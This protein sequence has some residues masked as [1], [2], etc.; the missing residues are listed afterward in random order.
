MLCPLE[1]TVSKSCSTYVLVSQMKGL[2]LPLLWSK[3]QNNVKPTS[4]LRFGP[5]IIQ[6]E[7]MSSNTSTYYR[8][9]YTNYNISIIHQISQNGICTPTGSTHLA[10]FTCT[11]NSSWLKEKP[12]ILQFILT[13][14]G[15]TLFKVTLF[16]VFQ[17]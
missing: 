14:E 5:R 6:I 9:F 4:N 13:I 1:S 3:T 15:F 10:S 11:F 17:K 16:K 2:S 7:D 8:L 12:G